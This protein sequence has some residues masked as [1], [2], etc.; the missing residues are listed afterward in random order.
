MTWKDD[1]GIDEIIPAPWFNDAVNGLRLPRPNPTPPAQDNTTPTGRKPSSR[2]KTPRQ[3]PS[4]E[5]K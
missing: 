3:A 5:K 1:N 2:T 4:K